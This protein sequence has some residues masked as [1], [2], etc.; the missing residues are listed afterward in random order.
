MMFNEQHARLFYLIGS[1][2]HDMVGGSLKYQWDVQKRTLTA[3]FT[4]YVV[5]YKGIEHRITD[6]RIEVTL[7]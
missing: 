2:I 4:D 7:A 6:G 5:S 3:T 1:V